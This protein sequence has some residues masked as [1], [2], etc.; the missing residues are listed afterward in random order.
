V[1]DTDRSAVYDAEALVAGMVDRGAEV[2]FHGTRLI[3]EPDR[4]FGQVADID[5]YLRWVRAHSWGYPETPAPVVRER[6]GTAKAAW[7][8]PG[9]I[10]VPDAAWARRELVVL[11]EYAHHAVWH[12]AAPGDTRHSAQFCRVLADLV[13]NAVGPSTGLLLTDAFFG[14][15]LMGR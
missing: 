11:H 2:R 15:G 14:A 9:T 4:R 3:P 5:R 8:S 10:A 12:T 6:R 7:E 1:I 13:R